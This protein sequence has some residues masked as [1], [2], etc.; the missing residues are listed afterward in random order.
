MSSPFRLLKHH[1]GI[2]CGSCWL[3]KQDGNRLHIFSN[4]KGL[5]SHLRK[6]HTL[7]E[8]EIKQIRRVS[9]KYK[10]GDSFLFL[11]FQRGLIY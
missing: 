4:F 10:D 2:Q 1:T 3:L 5:F 11:C 8:I 7:T 9:R 6:S